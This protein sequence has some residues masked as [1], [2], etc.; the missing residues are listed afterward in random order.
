M[1][2]IDKVTSRDFEVPADRLLPESTAGTD[3]GARE[4][5]RRSSNRL[6]HAFSPFHQRQDIQA[7]LP[8]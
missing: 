8:F 3:H 6:I 1:E 4:T 5:R 2:G 7:A